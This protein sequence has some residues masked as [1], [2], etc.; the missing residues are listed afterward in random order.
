MA[1]IIQNVLAACRTHGARLVFFDNVYMYGAVDGWMTEQS[2]HRPISEKGKIRA[3]LVETLLNAA[4][5][6]EVDIR[7]ARAADFYGPGATNGIPNILIFANLLKGKRP[8]WMG[9][10]NFRHSMTY[11]RDAARATA[12]LGI[13]ADLPNLQRIW[14]LPT[15][16]NALTAEEWAQQAAKALEVSPKKIQILKPWMLQIGGL[17]QREV[18]ELPEMLYQYN[19]DYLFSSEKFEKEFGISPTSYAK[20]IQETAKSIKSI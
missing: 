5:K 7:I 9:G 12:E 8:Q 20:G 14:H 4:D 13:R 16:R 18:K 3:L 1:I 11:T 17:F 6:G 2:P 10:G 15:D 19:R